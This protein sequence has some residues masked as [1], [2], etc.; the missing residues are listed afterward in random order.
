VAESLGGEIV[1]CDSLQ[2]YRGFDAGTGKPSEKD[3]RRVPHWIVDVADPR[4]DY[5]VADYVR[6]AGGA[7]ASIAGRGA[8]PIVVGGTGMYLRA[9]LK[10]LVP[11]P[12]RDRTS[13]R[14]LFSAVSK[15]DNLIIINSARNEKEPLQSP[16]ATA[17]KV[18][19]RDSA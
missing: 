17:P 3:R 18:E 4:R 2:V 7:I 10:G 16:T 12:P 6:D 8:V 5:S 1:G 13:D 14:S 11:A 15:L 19:V 9:L